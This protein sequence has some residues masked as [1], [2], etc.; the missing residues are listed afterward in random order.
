MAPKLIYCANGNS[1]FASIAINTGF[2]YGA[3]L[4]GKIYY[5]ICFADQDWKKPNRARYM[6]EL[7]KHRPHMATVLDLEQDNQLDEVLSWAIEAAQFVSTVV[8]IPKVSGII[9]KL[10]Q[11]IGETKVCL[12]YSVPTRFGRTEVPVGEFSGWPVHLLGGP[13]HR[14]MKLVNSMNIQSVDSN[15]HL[16]IATRHCKFWENGR[17]IQ[18]RPKRHDGPYHA[19]ERSCINIMQAWKN[20]T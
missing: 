18:V 5:P 14:Q 10:P 4:P 2:H 15:Y 20:L 19:F 8:I 9:D 3:Q 11:Q 7:A 6:E 17:W 13:P 12:G 1:R 16:L